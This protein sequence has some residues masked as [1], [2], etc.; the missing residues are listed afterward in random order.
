M[1]R[2]QDRQRAAEL[3]AAMNA[4][5]ARLPR[6]WPKELPP[7]NPAPEPPTNTGELEHD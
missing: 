7:A 3:A 4:A 5:A 6:G 1:I 2:D